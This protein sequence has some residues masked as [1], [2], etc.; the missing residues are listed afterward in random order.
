MENDKNSK[1]P[2]VTIVIPSYNRK[3][4][5]IEC[6][7]SVLKGQ[8]MNYELIVVD[9]GS[10]DGTCDTLKRKFSN[11]SNIKIIQSEKNLGAS[12]GRNLGI[13][14]TTDGSEYILFLD[15]DIVMEGNT[16][17]RMV[18]IMRNDTQ[19]GIAMP[20]IYY[21]DNPTKLQYAI[22]SVSLT[23]GFNYFNASED[24]D[25]SS[26]VMDTQVVPSVALTRRDVI[27]KIG[28]Y[29]EEFF[30]GYSDTEFCLRAKNAGFR[31]VC[32]PSLRAY[33][34]FPSD[35]IEA[36]RKW[37]SRA[38]YTSRNKIIFMKKY[39]KNFMLFLLFY[40]TI[41]FP[42]YMFISL[43]LRRTDATKNFLKGT[44]SGLRS[45]MKG[46]SNISE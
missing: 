17:L 39:S 3:E 23:T 18:S 35:P 5:V 9:N 11:I 25:Q 44:I 31:I 14:H 12:G 27:N 40:F 33:H 42:Y 26:G 32:I 10:T 41:F 37:L 8:Y 45:V 22:S 15:S 24:R 28:G 2:K 46:S 1:M 36:K 34:K 20:K 21:Y 16:L 29:D 38:Y 4:D 30:R 7:E 13:K 43:V 19:I 6:I